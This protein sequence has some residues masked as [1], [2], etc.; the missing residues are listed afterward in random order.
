MREPSPVPA[1]LLTVL[2]GACT[3]PTVAGGVHS[4]ASV[5]PTPAPPPSAPVPTWEFDGH[6]HVLVVHWP[7]S[8][9]ELLSSSLADPVGLRVVAQRGD[10]FELLEHCRVAGSYRREARPSTPYHIPLAGPDELSANLPGFEGQPELA[11]V[12]SLVDNGLLR[13]SAWNPSAPAF[14][15]DCREATH[16]VDTIELGAGSLARG[17][18]AE[19]FGPATIDGE[20]LRFGDTKQCP[21]LQPDPSQPSSACEQ[22]WAV[23]LV[24]LGEDLPLDGCPGDTGYDGLLCSGPKRTNYCGLQ[25][26]DRRCSQAR[27]AEP[28]LRE[29]FEQ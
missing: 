1:L 23:L 15:G 17:T 9:L 10:I 19:P 11:L 21:N 16:V 28:R 18:Y 5:E 8:Q 27:G 25:P 4:P 12:F 13:A 20:L 7:T 2:L 29:L 14:D 6:R 26:K 3:E 24:A 22:P